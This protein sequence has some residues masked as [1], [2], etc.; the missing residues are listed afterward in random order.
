MKEPERDD[1]EQDDPRE[2]VE[3]AKEAVQQAR[4]SLTG[5][6]GPVG[7]GGLVVLVGR[8]VLARMRRWLRRLRPR[9]KLLRRFGFGALI[10]LLSVTTCSFG[11]DTTAL[12]ADWGEPIPATT[13]DARRVLTR[14]VDVIQ[15]AP[16]TG[17][18][19]LTV[20]ESEATSALSM[21][22]M[23]SDLMLVAGRIPQEEIQQAPDLEAMR[24]RIW[25]ESDRMRDEIAANS[26]L[27][28]RILLKLDPR[29]RTGNIQVRFEPTGEVVVAGYVQAW[30]FRQPGIF[31]VAPSASE[32]EMVLD[33]VSG[34]LGRLPVPETLFDWVGGMV[35]RGILLGQG[36]A[37]VSEISV[38]DGTLTF[39]ARAAG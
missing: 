26:P 21:G 3:Q 1:G 6:V 13:E 23:M 31:V 22:L 20:T 28:Q 35:A 9:G 29:I 16:E 38:G 37:E 25:E 4:R 12:T 10:V 15:R 5:L 19:R 32:G 39:A 18:V 14:G 11:V 34:R 36:Y 7:R 24:V 8:M 30:R 27:A 2:V 33:F 17:A